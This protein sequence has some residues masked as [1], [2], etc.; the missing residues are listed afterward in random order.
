MRF[1]FERFAELVIMFVGVG[2][3]R[4]VLCLSLRPCG[5]LRLRN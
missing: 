3:L 4:E 5:D 2:R 1:W